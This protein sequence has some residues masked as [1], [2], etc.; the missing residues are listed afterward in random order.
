LKV[1]T[2]IGSSWMSVPAGRAG[3]SSYAFPYATMTL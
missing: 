1:A 3:G 2:I